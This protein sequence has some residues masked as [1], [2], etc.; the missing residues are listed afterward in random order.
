MQSVIF[1]QFPCF[2]FTF[3]GEWA[4]CFGE[5]DGPGTC[6]K[7][8]TYHIVTTCPIKRRVAC[9]FYDYMSIISFGSSDYYARD[10]VLII[11]RV[12]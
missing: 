8:D 1:F 12:G 7:T 9:E 11:P 4:T 3:G 6:G 5:M 10:C 2:T